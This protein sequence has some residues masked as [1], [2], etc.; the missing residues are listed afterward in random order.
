MIYI[1][2]NMGPGWVWTI[3]LKFPDY[4]SKSLLVALQRLAKEAHKACYNGLSPFIYIHMH[5]TYHKLQGPHHSGPSNH[6]YGHMHYY[7]VY[8]F[9]M[10]TGTRQPYTL[11]QTTLNKSLS[12]K[13]NSIVMLV[14]NFLTL[15]GPQWKKIYLRGFANNT[16][17]DQPAHLHSLISLSTFVIRF[18][19]S[20]IF[21][22]ATCEISITFT[23]T[24][25]GYTPS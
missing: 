17:A 1:W 6:M 4:L 20:T 21:T 10:Y 14:Y 7:L 8:T 23:C 18:L 19:V 3:I 22:L 12:A 16:G 25:I 24:T 15:F 2:L 5:S 9:L 13:S 11:K